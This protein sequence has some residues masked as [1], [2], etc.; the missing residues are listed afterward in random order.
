MT[1]VAAKRADELFQDLLNRLALLR[2]TFEI[3]LTALAWQ[4]AA[5]VV[6]KLPDKYAVGSLTWKDKG[7]PVK[8][9]KVVI[10][11][12]TKRVHPHERVFGKPYIKGPQPVDRARRYE[13]L[14]FERTGK[15]SRRDGNV[16]YTCVDES[17]SQGASGKPAFYKM[18]RDD[19]SVIKHVKFSSLVSDWKHIP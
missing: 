14:L 13:D 4:L 15:W 16:T 6:A 11:V 7:Q 10:P 2:D 1:A 12:K 19:N 9:A 8:K 3:Q 17:L 18:K 5:E